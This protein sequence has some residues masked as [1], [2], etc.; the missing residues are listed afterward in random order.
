MIRASKVI[1]ST[2]SH[3][4]FPLRITLS[5]PGK[6]I[7]AFQLISTAADPSQRD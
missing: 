7:N 6:L 1:S 2:P 3:V 4:E 5:D